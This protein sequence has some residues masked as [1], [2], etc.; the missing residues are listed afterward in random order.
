[1]SCVSCGEGGGAF[2][3]KKEGEGVVLERCPACQLVYR[4]G[5]DEAFDE[6]LYDYYSRRA[7]WPLDDVYRPI[8][9]QRIADLLDDLARRVRGR[10][11]LDVGCG[12]GIVVH[13]ATARGWHARGI[14]LSSPAIAIAKRFNATCE[15]LDFFAPDLDG[16]RFDV[17]VMSELIE[18]VPSP[19]RFLRRASE[20]LV[21][22][23]IVYLT[24]PNFQSLTWPLVGTAW[25]VVHEQ[26]LSYFTPRTFRALVRQH[27]DLEVASL[28]S[29]NVSPEVIAKVTRLL[30][31]RR[32]ACGGSAAS[33]SHATETNGSPSLA[34]DAAA[35]DTPAIRARVEGSRVLRAAKRAANFAL[36]ATNLG[37]T[38][39]VVLQKP[40]AD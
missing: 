30:R 8:N 17:I 12:A 4:R 1:M 25:S 5:W 32:R 19:A 21:P 24:T 2:V 28:E 31:P 13:V 15:R 3:A 35:V 9:R 39:F 10:T 27:T 14:D 37:E 20:L 40:K 22:G 38:L 29:R 18:H 7:D 33:P 11:L 36:D 6:G 26:H 16:E 23:G 34:Q